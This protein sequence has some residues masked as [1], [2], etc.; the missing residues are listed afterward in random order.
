MGGGVTLV[1]DTN[2]SGNPDELPFDV[3]GNYFN[4]VSGAAVLV[5]GEG[6][7]DG[8]IGGDTPANPSGPGT[9]NQGNTIKQA[10][11]LNG[12]AEDAIRLDDDG[13]FH[14]GL[15]PV[16]TWRILVKNNVIDAHNGVDSG[17]GDLCSGASGDQGIT[18]FVRDSAGTFHGTFTS[19]TVAD[20]LNQGMRVFVADRD[21]A[22][23]V[24]NGPNVFLTV[25]NNSF[26]NV[27]AAE[28]ISMSVDD[29]ADLC[30]NVTG[31]TV[32]GNIFLERRVATTTFL[33]PQASTAAIS[34]ANGG[35]P[36]TLGA[37]PLTFNTNCNVAL[38]TNP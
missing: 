20:P 26:A 6:N 28:G 25:N 27:G 17:G 16:T 36:V 13:N 34:A 4:L 18:V 1:T 24:S 9:V 14:A 38:P 10:G 11:S 31:N 37:Q 2:A 29:Q 23:G 30:A 22:D 3:Q 7:A 5:V 8:R 32:D 19:N 21:A 33:V 12:C 35:A 15:A